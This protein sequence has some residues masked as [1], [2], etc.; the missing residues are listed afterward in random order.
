MAQKVKCSVST[1]NQTVRDS[2]THAP[3]PAGRSV[4]HVHEPGDGQGRRAHSARY[5]E[6]A[7]LT[8]LG[9]DPHASYGAKARYYERYST[10]EL[11]ATGHLEEVDDCLF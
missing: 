11:L 1:L 6:G 10:E 2:Y 7:N 4:R 3:E 9:L 8:H 5:P